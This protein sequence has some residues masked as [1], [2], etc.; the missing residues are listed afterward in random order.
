VEN[1][2]TPE[3]SLIDC[4]LYNQEIVFDVPKRNKLLFKIDVIVRKEFNAPSLVFL[5]NK[6]VKMVTVN[7]GV[8][9]ILDQNVSWTFDSRRSPTCYWT[10][11][12]HK[13]AQKNNL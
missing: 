5:S 9:S 7:S 13:I 12:Y 8:R 10:G 6:S 11:F 1:I 2:P 4:L 3:N